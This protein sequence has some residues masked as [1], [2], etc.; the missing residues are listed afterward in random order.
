MIHRRFLSGPLP[1]NSATGWNYF[2]QRRKAKRVG[3]RRAFVRAWACFFG[4]GS[5]L[6]RT[7]LAVALF[8]MR[9]FAAN[10]PDAVNS[11]AYV[12]QGATGSASGADWGN[13]Y[14]TLPDT[15]VRGCTYWI[16][17][18]SYAGHLFKVP[19]SGTSTITVKAPT[20]ANHGT[21]IGWN[22][23]YQ[24]QA[25][26]N[27]KDNSSVGDVFTFQSDYYVID[28]SYRSTATGNPQ[29]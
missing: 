25:V 12:R 1:L 11:A 20:I 14:T 2:D 3:V 6:R 27:T 19:D 26:F 17:A 24:G 18:G 4:R 13:A 8:G 15:L 10:C 22:N 16:A 23:Q 28:G 7:L 21:A 5:W 9:C 29:S